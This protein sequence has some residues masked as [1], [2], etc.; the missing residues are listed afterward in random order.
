MKIYEFQYLSKTVF[1]LTL[2]NNTF[3]RI[4]FFFSFCV[5]FCVVK[6]GAKMMKKKNWFKWWRWRK[7]MTKTQA[8]RNGFFECEF[9][10]FF[11]LFDEFTEKSTRFVTFKTNK[12]TTKNSQFFFYLHQKWVLEKKNK[13]LQSTADD[14]RNF[15][16]KIQSAH[17]LKNYLH[18]KIFS[19]LDDVIVSHLFS[20]FH[21]FETFESRFFLCD[22]FYA[23]HQK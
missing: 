8:T 3:S 20:F 14:R 13:R 10:P 6:G 12:N 15:M 17:F 18:I 1:F 22:F 4:F 19:T 16:T 7:R 11:L 21:P 2:N 9:S 23:L 5:F